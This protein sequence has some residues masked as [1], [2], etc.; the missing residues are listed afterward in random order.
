MRYPREHKV[1]TREKLVRE[2]GALAKR[3]G[4]AGS[5]VDAL[6]QAAG[7]TSGAF[8]KHFEGKDALLAAICE[9]ELAATGARF[10]AIEPG[11]REQIL[12]VIDAYLSVA[13]VRAPE[14][15][16]LLPSLSPEIARASQTTREAFERAFHELAAVLAE[17]VGDPELGSALVTQCVGAVTIARALA[18]E[19][20]Q[21]KVLAAAR[22]S[23]RR[24]LA[25]WE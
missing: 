12:R 2:S 23:V 8:Y 19:A 17:K 9:G 21:R 13:H 3:S 20:A 6:A 1:I 24:L 11:S 10:A 22:E 5:G 16:C 4:F 14:A 7:L 15:G 18:S 25:S